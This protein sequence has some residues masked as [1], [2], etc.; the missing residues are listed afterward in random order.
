[1]YTSFVNWYTIVGGIFYILCYSDR[2]YGSMTPSK[3]C[4]ELFLYYMHKWHGFHPKRLHFIF[5]YGWGVTIFG[6]QIV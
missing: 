6:P 2:P 5:T 3:S 1:M 4:S